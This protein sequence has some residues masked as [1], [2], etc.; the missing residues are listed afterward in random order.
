MIYIKIKIKVNKEVISLHDVDDSYNSSSLILGTLHLCVP[1]LPSN[2]YRPSVGLGP[3][4][5]F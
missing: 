3:F 4:I 2:A 5:F 1:F